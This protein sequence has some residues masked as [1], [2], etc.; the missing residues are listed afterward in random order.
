M[1]AQLAGY[2]GKVEGIIETLAAEAF[3]E[4]ARQAG[5]TVSAPQERAPLYGYEEKKLHLSRV[6]EK[7]I[8]S[9]RAFR[10]Q[11]VEVFQGVPLESGQDQLEV[12]VIKLWK[13]TIA[14]ESRKVL[15]YVLGVKD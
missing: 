12:Q 11:A 10:R 13:D 1:R 3:M 6:L 5:L 15:A 2:I 9:T 7:G 14:S 8:G 4:R